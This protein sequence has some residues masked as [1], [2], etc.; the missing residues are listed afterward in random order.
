MI[1]FVIDTEEE[2]KKKREL[3]DSLIGIKSAVKMSEQKNV[4]DKRARSEDDSAGQV[5]LEHPTDRTY[6]GLNC[7]IK[8]MA[9]ES[10][11]FRMVEEFVTNTKDT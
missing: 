5:L 2:V 10:K 4:G 1:D 7:R 11:K 3:V 8:P 9:A 6:K